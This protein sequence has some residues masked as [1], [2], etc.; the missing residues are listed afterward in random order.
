MYQRA[1]H[2]DWGLDGHATDDGHYLVITVTEGTDPRKRVFYQ[3]LT[4]AGAPVTALLTNFDADYSFV[5]NDGPLFWFFTDLDAPRGRVIGIDVTRPERANWREII[6]QGADA[7]K[8]VTAVNNSF[9]CTYLKDAHSQVK[10][11]SLAGQPLRDIEL[12]GL[13][14]ADG[15]DGKRSD[16]ETFYSFT[17]FTAPGTIYRADL[18]AGTSGVFREPKVGFNPADFE[19]VQVFYP[20]KDGT[21]VPMFITS[22]KGLKRDGHTPTVLYGYGGFD[23]SITPSFSVG[24]LVWMEMGGIYAVA[25]LR[26]GGEYG[27]QWHLAGA[28]ANKQNVF[29]D[30]IAAGEWLVAN[31]YT[32]PPRLWRFMAAATADCSSAPV[33]RN[34]RICL[35]PRCRRSG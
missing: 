17:S 4:Q 6:P 7:L 35:A 25:N 20:S 29:D 10:V 5:D 23:I 18:T 9:V 3:D 8:G 24:S 26:G 1:D 11:F 15:F 34:G 30:F 21:R 13:G 32:C 33:K 28:K 2:K 31:H 12:P 16:T 27:E 14:T 22:R 19:T